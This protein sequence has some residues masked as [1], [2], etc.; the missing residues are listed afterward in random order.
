MALLQVPRPPSRASHASRASVASRGL[1]LYSVGSVH[2]VR[3]AV[4]R[5]HAGFSQPADEWRPPVLAGALGTSIPRASHITAVYAILQ[6]LFTIVTGTFDVYV[7]A[8]AEPGKNHYGYYIISFEFVY[9][10]NA[11][12]RRCLMVLA[13]VSAVSGIVLLVVSAILLR[14]LKTE[15]ERRIRP[16]LLFMIFHTIWRTFAFVFSSIVNDMYFSYHGVMCFLWAVMV[17]LN[18][19]GW[20]V[21]WSFFNELAEV[22]KLEDIAH[23]KLTE[24][25][26]SL[27][28]TRPS[29]SDWERQSLAPSAL[30]P[31]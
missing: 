16:W 8:E 10:G 23:L 18:V 17:L 12:V 29:V 1:S 26:S 19:Y 27:N 4:A 9:V 13:L 24:R 25:A 15:D 20:L 6:A 22:S 5:S 2:S 28:T 3:S 30:L 14:A 7:L 31:L 11:H 21:V